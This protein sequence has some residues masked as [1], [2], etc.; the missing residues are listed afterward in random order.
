VVHVIRTGERKSVC[1]L[2]AAAAGGGW[3]GSVFVSG[4]ASCSR[5]LQQLHTRR[6]GGVVFTRE[7]VDALREWAEN[8]DEA[9]AV[10]DQSASGMDTDVARSIADRIAALLPPRHTVAD[11]ERT[12]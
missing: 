8:E 11:P 3:R 6:V 1:G 10:M 7:D 4:P 5:C 2:L 9:R 12:P